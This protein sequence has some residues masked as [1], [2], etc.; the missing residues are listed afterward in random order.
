SLRTRRVLVV[1]QASI[2]VAVRN[3]G[4][5]P[6]FGVSLQL[7]ASPEFRI[8]GEAVRKLSDLGPSDQRVVELVV[9]PQKKGALSLEM[10]LA[11]DNLDVKGKA[12]R[13]A[14]VVEIIN[15]PPPLRRIERNP[16]IAGPPV[17]G[18]EM[19]FGRRDVF[20]HVQ[21]NLAGRFQDN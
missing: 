8:I 6:A 10:K 3:G 12:S 5:H 15:E 11:W 19:F 9:K 4:Q 16:Y 20:R 14:E 1:G 7:L 17:K 2:L 21:E 13:Q 18:R